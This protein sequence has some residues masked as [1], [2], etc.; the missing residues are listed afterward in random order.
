MPLYFMHIRNST[1]VVDDHE[2]Q[3]LDD[4]DHARSEAVAGIR[5]ILAEELLKGSLDFRGRIDITDGDGNVL[6]VVPF[7]EVVTVTFDHDP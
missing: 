2:G 3:E 4:I 5:S 1:G 7:S 6:A